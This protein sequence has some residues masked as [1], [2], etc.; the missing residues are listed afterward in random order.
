MIRSLWQLYTKIYGEVTK[1]VMEIS[2]HAPREGSDVL[3]V[4][5]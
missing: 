3:G 5:M 1:G 2:I 4:L